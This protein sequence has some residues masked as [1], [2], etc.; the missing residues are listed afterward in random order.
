MGKVIAEFTMS[1]DGFIAAPD[2]DVRPIFAWY[3]AGDTEL[4]MPNVPKFKLSR[5]SA[6]LL[7][8]TWEGIGA[9]VTG[10][11]DFDASNAWGGQPPLG[12]PTFVVTH[13]PPR[14]WLQEHSPFTFVTDGV[15]S[16]LAQA[17]AIAGNKV[18][19]ISGS[20]IVQQCLNAG[21]LDEVRI[22]LVPV[23]L[24][25]GI[26]LF[27]HLNVAPIQLETTTVLEGTGVTHLQFRVVKTKKR[28]KEE[29]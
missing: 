25:Q 3:F 16:A 26:R 15:A 24:G 11:G 23:L 22:H 12:V 27:D 18:V 20:S 19:G 6:E 1:L 2:G 17:Q 13:A 10:R 21:W 29:A 9:F 8:G 28:T 14:A 4:S 5:A 7:R